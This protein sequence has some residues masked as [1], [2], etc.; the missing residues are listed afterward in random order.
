[1]GTP[2]GTADTKAEDDGG[3]APALRVE[4]VPFNPEAL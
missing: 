4:L 2:Y 1:M 3:K